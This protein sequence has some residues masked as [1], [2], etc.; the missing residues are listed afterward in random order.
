MCRLPVSVR[1]PLARLVQSMPAGV[2]DALLC[3]LKPVFNRRG[4]P[5]RV[6]SKLYRIAELLG[7]TSIE[8]VYRSIVSFSGTANHRLLGAAEASSV[9]TDAD[10]WGRLA[11]PL[12]KMMYLDQVSYLPDDILVKVDRAAMAVSL[13][14]RVPL[15][16]H[17]LVEFAWQVPVEYKVR[18][19]RSKAILREV[20]AK[21]VPPALTERPK[22]G[23]GVPVG[24][25]L[26]G[27]LRDWAEDLLGERRLSEDGL[28]DVS[29]VRHMW[30]EHLSMRRDWEHQLWAV[31]MYQAWQRSQ[32]SSGLAC[33]A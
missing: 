13:E 17:R 9:L 30:Q 3:W 24:R 14:T 26:H 11:D 1:R 31:L 19:G 15:L 33:A 18:G 23:F 4:A 27:P 32:H 5:A 22:M 29:T 7:Q 25:W 20:L 8:G 12:E 10:R 28:L 6:S 16:D 21:Y 2:L